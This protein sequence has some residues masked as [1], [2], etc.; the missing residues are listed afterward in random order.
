M[1]TTYHFK[2]AAEINKD[3]MDAIRVAF[4]GKPIVITVEEEVDETAFL[5]AESENREMLK[6]SI[7]QDKSGESIHFTIQDAGE[8]YNL[9]PKHLS[10]IFSGRK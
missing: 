4:K 2:S 7:E 9:L 6:R 10:N 8:I 3:W 1:Y 5:L